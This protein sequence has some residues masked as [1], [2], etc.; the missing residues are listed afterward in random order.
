MWLCTSNDL[1]QQKNNKLFC[2]FVAGTGTVRFAWTDFKAHGA[3]VQLHVY[4]KVGRGITQSVKLCTPFVL[5]P[6]NLSQSEPS[7]TNHTFFFHATYKLLLGLLEHICA[8]EVFNKCPFNS[9]LLQGCRG[10]CWPTW[11]MTDI[12]KIHLCNLFWRLSTM[13]LGDITIR[14]FTCSVQPCKVVF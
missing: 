7:I 6:H 1:I 2:I 5:P 10:A 3:D 8:S 13:F 14:T 4:S 11:K 12:A 9:L